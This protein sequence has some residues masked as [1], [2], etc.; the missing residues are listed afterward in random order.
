MRKSLILLPLLL[1]AAPAL[2]QSAAAAAPA[3]SSPTRRSA[4][5]LA[6]AM[7][8]LSQALLDMQVG[9]VEAAVEGREP[10]PAEQ[11]R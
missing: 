3:A 8:A 1:C 4:D 6:D 2:A 7:Q 10:T 9:E 11:Q 5:Q